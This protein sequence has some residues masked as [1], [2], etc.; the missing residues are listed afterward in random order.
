MALPLAA[1]GHGGVDGA[2]VAEDIEAGRAAAEPELRSPGD[3][4]GPDHA[5]PCA[6]RM[7]QGAVRRGDGVLRRVQA[8]AVAQE[9][10][11]GELEPHQAGPVLGPRAHH[12]GRRPA[13]PRFPP[14]RQVGERRP[15]LPAPR[16]ASRHRRLPPPRP[17]PD[18]R[19]LHDPRPGEEVRAVRQVVAGEGVHRRRRRRRHVLHVVGGSVGEQPEAQQV[20]RAHAGPVLLG[21]SGGGEGA[22]GERPER[23][24]RGGA[25]DEA[26]GAA[27]VRE[28]LP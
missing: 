27:R 9:V 4:A 13:P 24:R 11:Q 18:E 7:V 25:G 19:E 26:G 15:L 23:A 5:V 17:P 6:D 21:E 14:P 1:A 12:A 8:A 28:L 22:D 3:A 10:R 16:R 20:R 2:A